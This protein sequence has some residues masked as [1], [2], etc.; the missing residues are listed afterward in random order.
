MSLYCG[1]DLHSTNHLVAITDEKDRRLFEQR[2][3]NEVSFTVAALAPYRDE[4]AGI[5]IESTFNWYWL[6]DGLQDAGFTP[7][8]ANPAAIKQYE[9]LKYTD[10]THDAFY[11]AK[12]MR[13]GILP[14]GYLYPREQRGVRDLLR[15]R[16]SLVRMA[17]CLLLSVQSQIW[18]STG[19][20]VSNNR[21][22]RADFELPLPAGPVYEGAASQWRLYQRTQDEIHTLEKLALDCYQGEENYQ[23]LQTVKG[24]GVI[25]GLTIGLETGPIER[26]NTAGNYASYCRCV[27]SLRTSDGKKK[28]ENNRKAGNRYLSWAFSEAAHFAVRYEPKVQRFYERKRQKRNGIVAIRAVAHKISRAVFHMLKHHE[29]FD[30]DRAFG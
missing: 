7:C 28:G 21:I 11:L 14:T 17:S 12:L 19:V 15:R 30:V 25:L 9:G 1:I 6:V 29:P 4:L 20:K 22:R 26:F 5:T 13:L 8:L 23:L 18:R 24:I 3:P 2:L 16:L 10:D 27:N